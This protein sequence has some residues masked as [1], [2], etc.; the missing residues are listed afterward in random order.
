[1]EI[2][3]ITLNDCFVEIKK[4]N[5]Y[6]AVGV[7][8]QPGGAVA[9]SGGG[10][11]GVHDFFQIVHLGGQH[12][13]EAVGPRRCEFFRVFG[14]TLVGQQD[15]EVEVGRPGVAVDLLAEAEIAAVAAATAVEPQK[16][17]KNNKKKINLHINEQTKQNQQQESPLPNGCV[18]QTRMGVFLSISVYACVL[19]V[20]FPRF[21]FFYRALVGFLCIA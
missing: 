15:L 11:G 19:H 21:G 4:F 17:Q 20:L 7:F 5:N 6:L 10:P 18:L 1:M 3:L 13:L 2:K 12:R 8:W 14:H 16:K 9:R